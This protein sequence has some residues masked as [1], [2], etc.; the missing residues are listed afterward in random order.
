[1]LGTIVN[2]L[3]IVVGG[4]IGIFFKNVFPQRLTDALL[5]ASG[6]AVI[7]LGIKLSL[8]GEET[9]LLIMSVIIGTGIGELLK[10]EERLDNLGNFVQ[11]KMKNKD[12]NITLG[13]VTCTLLYCVGSMSILGAIQSGLTGNHEILFSKSLLDLIVSITMAVSMGFGVV[14][15]AVSVLIYQ[16]SITILAQYM[17][18]LLSDAVVIEMTAIGGV[19]I[20][21]IGLNFLEIKRIKVGNMLPAVFLPI[22]YFLFV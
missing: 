15:S 12:S 17:Q 4:F 7:A 8:V 6:L 3:A 9:T 13:F 11:S 22:I 19:L 1:M 5:K 10:I 20:M 16:G 2:S 14:L 21:A 18:S